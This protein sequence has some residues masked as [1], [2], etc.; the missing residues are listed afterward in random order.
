MRE[1]MTLVEL[2]PQITLGEDS[3][4]QFKADIRNA[5]S[6]AAEPLAKP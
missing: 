5:E 3:S 4:R 6:L 2:L 1:S